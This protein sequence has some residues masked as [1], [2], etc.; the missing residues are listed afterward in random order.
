MFLRPGNDF[1]QHSN[2]FGTGGM[3]MFSIAKSLLYTVYCMG[4]MHHSVFS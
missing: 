3:T 4:N 1:Y 2:H